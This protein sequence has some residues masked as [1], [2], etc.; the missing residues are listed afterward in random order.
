M[1][2]Y[3]SNLPTY[4]RNKSHQSVETYGEVNYR[5]SMI[6]IYQMLNRDL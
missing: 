6:R 2:G 3:F 4:E 5:E 1:R